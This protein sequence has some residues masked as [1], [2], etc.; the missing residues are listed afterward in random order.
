MR[1][2]KTRWLLAASVLAIVMLLLPTVA[3]CS[4][5]NNGEKQPVVFADLSWDSAMVHNRIAAFIL[6]NG[7]GYPESSYTPGDTIPLTAGLAKGDIDVNMEVWYEN[8]QEAVDGFLAD[9]SITKMGVNYDDDW[10]GFLVPTYMIDEGQLP[11]D[12]SV[13]NIGQYWEFFK[14]PE[15]P[16]KGAFYSCIAGWSCGPINET[17]FE[18]Y[19]LD[20][21]FNVILPGSGAAL[22][23]SMTAAY[24]KHQ[25]WFG[26]YWAPTPALGQLDMTVVAEPA[27][28]QAT[29]DADKG[30][31]YP[32][33]SV[34]VYTNTTWKDAQ[35]KEVTD[36]L[37]AYRTTTAQNNDFLGW[38]DETGGSYQDAALYFLKNYEDTWTKWVS[39]DVVTKVKNALT[40]TS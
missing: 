1:K 10:Q 38:M 14:D 19:G 30:C 40:A 6:E 21:N 27:F 12:I 35:P 22:L 28:N 16:N 25:P 32:A 13:D 26:Y 5:S 8:Q 24:E 29:W 2:P 33:V 3:G 20:Q 11:A 31:E 37:S 23:A 9:G 18:T 4:S 17:K 34:D 15:D 7:F 36:F 39:D